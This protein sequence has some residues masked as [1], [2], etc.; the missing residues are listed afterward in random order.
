MGWDEA[1]R[2]QKRNATLDRNKQA[3]KEFDHLRRVQA[4][5]EALSIP[6]CPPARPDALVGRAQDLMRQAAALLAEKATKNSSCGELKEQS[7]YAAGSVVGATLAGQLPSREA[8]QRAREELAPR[9]DAFGA[10][11]GGAAV[12]RLGAADFDPLGRD[13][14][15]G[16]GQVNLTEPAYPMPARAGEL[17]GLLDLAHKKVGHVQDAVDRLESNLQ[18]VLNGAADEAGQPIEGLSAG[19]DAGVCT[20]NLISRLESVYARLEALRY[21]LAV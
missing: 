4:E 6:T 12:G 19:S 16:G 9:A 8:A 13:F 15:K 7:L 18:S 3:A 11:G 17:A 20:A 14:L 1:E 21:R 10:L 2:E 5:L